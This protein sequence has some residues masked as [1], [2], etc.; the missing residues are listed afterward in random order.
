MTQQQTTQTRPQVITVFQ[1][2]G[3]LGAY[4]VGAYQAL[5][6]AGLH[7]DWVS[8]ISIGAFTAALVAGN[9]PEKRLERLEEFWRE[10]SW[11]GSEWGSLLKG[12]MRRLFNLGSHMTGLLFG[13][14]GF[15]SPRVIPPA[16]ALPGTPEAMSFYSTRPMHSTLRRLVDFEYINSRATRLSLGASRVSDGQ[17]V[18]FDNT[19]D[20][21]GPE[22]VLAS[23]A[24]PPAFPPSRINGELY[25]DGGCVTN[26][27]LNAILDDPPKRR[28]VVFMIDL[29]DARAPEPRTL[30]EAN[31]RMKSIQFAGRSSGHVDQFATV[32][33]L[34]QTVSRVTQQASASSPVAFSDAP[35]APPAPRLDIIHLT[36]QRGEHQIDNSDAEFSRAS[37]AER[38]ADGYRDMKKALETFPWTQRTAPEGMPQAFSGDDGDEGAVVH[39]LGGEKT[40]GR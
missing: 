6:E 35:E 10:V 8:G 16:L 3:A 2:G 36:Y 20:T 7:P 26:T 30:E 1:G 38:R 24:L 19:R 32:W 18:F 4:H 17:L 23:G 12:P 34:R 40:H 22:H 15:F 27:P 25:W 29:F 9:R 21:L 39:R 5:E 33:N 11:P 14:P 28:T 13:Q 31:W 37:I